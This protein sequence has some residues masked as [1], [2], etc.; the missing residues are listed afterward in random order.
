MPLFHTSIHQPKRKTGPFACGRTAGSEDG[1]H[2]TRINAE[3]QYTAKKF[4]ELT[5]VNKNHTVYR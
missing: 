4:K 5:T 1:S 2:G 3:T